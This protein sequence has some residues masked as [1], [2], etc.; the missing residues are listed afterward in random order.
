MR[1]NKL[2]ELL[3]EGK[4]TV[5]TAIVCP[6]PGI[7]ELIGRTGMFDYVEF[8]GEYMPWDLHDLENLSRAVEL[9]DM[10]S[11]MKADQEPRT[12]IAQRSLGFRIYCSQMCARWKTPRNAWG[13]S[14]WKRPRGEAST[15]ATRAGAWD[16]ISRPGHGRMP[17]PWTKR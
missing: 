12:F 9:F 4:P 13:L 14:S 17:S 8:E 2:R 10:S 5:G 6:W 3:R 11:M 1:R 15:G 16:T 7:V